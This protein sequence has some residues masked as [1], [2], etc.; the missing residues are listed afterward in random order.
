[1]ILYFGITG[2]ATARAAS[3]YLSPSSGNYTIGDTFS[4]SV[5]LSSLDEAVNAVSGRMSFSSDKLEA[6]SVSGGDAISMWIQ[7][8]SYG[9]GSISFDGV[10]LNPGFQGSGGSVI[11]AI[12][13]AKEEGSAHISFSSGSILANDGLGILRISITKSKRR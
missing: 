9:S 3:M 13:K 1:M 4:V 10:I 5:M 12:F 8:P 2:T 6:I 11:T 7:T